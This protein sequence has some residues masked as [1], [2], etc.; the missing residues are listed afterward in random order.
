M[1]DD[2]INKKVTNPC[3]LADIKD[4]AFETNE[5]KTVMDEITFISSRI[6]KLIF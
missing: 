6:K 3:I 4:A 5:F 1:N 2:R